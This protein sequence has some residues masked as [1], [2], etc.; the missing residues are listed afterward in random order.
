MGMKSMLDAKVRATYA[1][2][3]RQRS[4]QFDLKTYAQRYIELYDQLIAQHDTSA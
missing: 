1:E 2:S 3:A 4:K